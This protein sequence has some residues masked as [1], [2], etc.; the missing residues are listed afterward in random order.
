MADACRI[1]GCGRPAA[2]PSRD[3]LCW[4]HYK[5][6]RKG[7]PLD[8]ELRPW[9]QPAVTLRRAALAYNEADGDEEFKRAERRLIMAGKRMG[10]RPMTKMS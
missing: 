3:G 1:D 4:G 8:V 5:R 9:G 2:V 6:A 10:K 7:L